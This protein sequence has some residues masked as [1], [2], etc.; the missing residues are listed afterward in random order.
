MFH[1]P[2]YLGRGSWLARR[3]PRVLIL[4]VVGAATTVIQ[5]WDARIAVVLLAMA[6]VYYRAAGIP[7]RSVRR[8]WEFAVLFVSI[9]VLVNTIFTGGEVG[10]LRLDDVMLVVWQNAARCDRTGRCSTWL[11][12]IAHHKALKALARSVNKPLP[13]GRASYEEVSAQENPESL[14]LHQEL[15]STLAH[16]LATL[17]AAQRTV[18]ELTLYQE[19]SY[20]DIAQ[21]TGCP[22]NTV[23]TRMFHARRR[24]VA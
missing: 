3:D 20:Q 11:F 9:L 18:V 23:K 6:L 21:I 1:A 2:R 14:V 16:A 19:Y 4:V 17:S 13:L 15:G 7:W 22:L 12:G 5:V 10:G 8:Q 24:L